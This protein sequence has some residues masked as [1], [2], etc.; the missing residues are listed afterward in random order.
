MASKLDK[1]YISNED[2]KIDE[3]CII[4]K[5]NSDTEEYDDNGNKVSRTPKIREY[6]HFLKK[7]GEYKD[8]YNPKQLTLF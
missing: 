1:I 8:L 4:P 7:V 5:E 6:Q 2:I 3:K